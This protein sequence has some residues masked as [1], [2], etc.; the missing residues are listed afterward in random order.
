M[1]FRTATGEAREPEHNAQAIPVWGNTFKNPVVAV[2]DILRTPGRANPVALLQPKPRLQDFIPGDF[3]SSN[4]DNLNMDLEATYIGL[5]E[6][7]RSLFALS[8]ERY[9]LVVFSPPNFNFLGK[10][11]AT[12]DA[13]PDYVPNSDAYSDSLA[14]ID[15]IPRLLKE[16]AKCTNGR[17][18]RECVV[19][20]RPVA[21]DSQSRLSRLLPD[22]PHESLPSLRY[23]DAPVSDSSSNYSGEHSAEE[24]DGPGTVLGWK[25]TLSS[26]AFACLI[27]LVGMWYLSKPPMDRKAPMNSTMHQPKEEAAIHTGDYALPLRPEAT[28]STA[29]DFVIIPSPVTFS[30]QHPF[31][32]ARNPPLSLPAAPTAS[33]NGSSIAIVEDDSE[34]EEQ[35]QAEVAPG[36]K[37]GTRRRRRGK[38][39]RGDKAL[40]MES[41]EVDEVPDTKSEEEAQESQAADWDPQRMD[42]QSAQLIVS[43]DVL[44]TNN[45]LVFLSYLS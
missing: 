20:K 33:I 39:N 22:R 30:E 5:V 10:R 18:E 14:S 26:G 1:A 25:A 6:E 37:K 21:A 13:P 29:D 35:D 41:K 15:S 42:S 38:K 23:S 31:P 4:D 28:G 2:F 3:A 43:E 36:K 40:S 45:Y 8:P 19:G 44:G 27:F 16:Q 24:I 17:W 9:P 11:L 12:I 34:A 32:I 7:T